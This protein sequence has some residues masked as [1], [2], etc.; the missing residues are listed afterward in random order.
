MTSD[1]ACMFW[2]DLGIIEGVSILHSICSS[3]FGLLY[4]VVYAML[5]AL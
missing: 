3:T 5:M 2:N 1:V 4:S